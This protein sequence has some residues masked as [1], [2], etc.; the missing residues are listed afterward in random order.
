MGMTGLIIDVR[1]N[2][3]GLMPVV[4]QI[5][6][7]LVPEGVIT[8]T[9]HA[10]GRREYHRATEEYLGLPLAVL[11]NGRSASA[12]E[13][14]GA[15]VQDTRAG[16]LVGTQTYGKGIVQ[17][18]MYLSDG[19]AVKMTIAKYFTPNGISI[20]GTGVTPD[21]IV[22]MDEERTRRINTLEWE[23]DTQLQTAWEALYALM[24]R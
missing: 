9:E 3:G 14:L 8:Y 21:I 24:R 2:P 23:E 6:N 10:D 1:N 11:V 7:R 22:E 4:V 5:T 17:N 12:S 16:I 20:H 15:A 18:L 13:I 19:N